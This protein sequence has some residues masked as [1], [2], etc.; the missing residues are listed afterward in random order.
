MDAWNTLLIKST[1]T[2]GDAWEHLNAQGGTGST[3][4]DPIIVGETTK[5][6]FDNRNRI[7]RVVKTIIQET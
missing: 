7:S 2:T 1:I 5:V 3:G 4:G 6:Y